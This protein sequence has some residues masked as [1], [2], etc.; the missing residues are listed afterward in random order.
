MQVTQVTLRS[1]F[2][3]PC[4]HQALIGAHYLS[5]HTICILI[6]AHTIHRMDII[7][8]VN[9]LVHLVPFLLTLQ[10]YHPS[11]NRTLGLFHPFHHVHNKKQSKGICCQALEQSYQE[12]LWLWS[13]I[14]AK[15]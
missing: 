5:T 11:P 8:T 13:S 6:S 10:L 7:Q 1:M 2:Q 15:S 3:V 12:M 4:A 14:L 9:H